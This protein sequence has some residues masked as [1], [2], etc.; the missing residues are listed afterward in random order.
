MS[1]FL[2]WEVLLSS[3]F[4]TEPDMLLYVFSSFVLDN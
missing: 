3:Y 4:K 2:Y 1:A